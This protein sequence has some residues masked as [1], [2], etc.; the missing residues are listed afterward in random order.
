M[1]V[2]ELPVDDMDDVDLKVVNFVDVS[3]SAWYTK[4]LVSAFKLGILPLPG[5]DGGRLE[6]DTYMTRASAASLIH[7]AMKADLLLDRQPPEEEEEEEEER[8][9]EEVTGDMMDVVFPFEH[10]GKFVMKKPFSYRFVV[11]GDEQAW[12]DA[13]LQSGQPGTLICR[14][15]KMEETGFS[16]EYYLGV[17]EG[18]RCLIRATLGSGTYQ[19]QLQ[20]SEKDVTYTVS[21]LRG[22]G[23]GNDGFSEAVSLPLDQLIPGTL[24]AGDLTDW[25][26]F[27]ISAEQSLMVEAQN[28]VEVTCLV[29][30]SADVDLAS[31]EGP[32]CNQSFSYT[33]GTYYIAVGRTAPVGASQTY[34]VYLKDVGSQ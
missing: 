22:Q 4:Y 7:N 6:P 29:Y 26:S 34:S 12:I 3:L 23:D 14:L 9:E 19:L 20:P 16:D 21:A 2:F 10:S 32:Q 15:Y 27:S 33:P 17:Q 25:Y 13:S 24:A 1:E 28:A 31:F 8:E 30:A 11:D 5:Q 18:S